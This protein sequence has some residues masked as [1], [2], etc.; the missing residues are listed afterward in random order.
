MNVYWL[1]KMN[2]IH[3]VPFLLYSGCA[4]YIIYPNYE[5]VHYQGEKEKKKVEN[6]EGYVRNIKKIWGIWQKNEY[7]LQNIKVFFLFIIHFSTGLC[8]T[9]RKKFNIL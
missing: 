4:Y 9:E 5:I 3:D 6:F 1:V 2:L 7:N 8:Y